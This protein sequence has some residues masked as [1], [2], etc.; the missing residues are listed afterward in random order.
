M[1][2]LLTAHKDIN[3]VLGENDSMVLGA[4]KAIQE[5]GKQPMKDI[6]V[7]ADALPL[8]TP[9]LLLLELL[10]LLEL[11]VL[12][13]LLPNLLLCPRTKISFWPSM[14]VPAVCGLH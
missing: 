2:N 7:F 4:I 10:E 9:L 5:A 13:V 6:F 3:V 8:V 11:L 1:E 12:L 14:W